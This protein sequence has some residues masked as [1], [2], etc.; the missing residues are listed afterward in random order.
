[1]AVQPVDKSRQQVRGISQW[2][3]WR[4]HFCRA[5]GIAGT[6]CELVCADAGEN[7]G[8]RACEYGTA[9]RTSRDS[10]IDRFAGRRGK[11]EEGAEDACDGY[12]RYRSIPQ[13]DSGK[14]GREVE[15]VGRETLMRVPRRRRE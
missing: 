1:M 10:E 7:A 11:G 14:R 6:D 2:R 13:R 5:Q 3:A 12:N 9:W 15:A 4:G 8:Q